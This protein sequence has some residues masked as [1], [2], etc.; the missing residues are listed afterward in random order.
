MSATTLGYIGYGKAYT[1]LAID[2]I[3]ERIVGG[4]VT[5]HHQLANVIAA[6][7]AT[8][9][10]LLTKEAGSIVVLDGSGAAHTITL[11]NAVVGLKYQF[12]VGVIGGTEGDISV[13]ADATGTADLIDGRILQTL[14]DTDTV[15][16]LNG[17]GILV[18]IDVP[19]VV[20]DSFTLTCYA[21][22]KW[23]IEGGSQTAA[24]FESIT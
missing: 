14:T 17:L 18:N 4:G 24:V 11:P 2:S 16:V 10:T 13:L 7:T 9:R 21:A 19:A 3:E 1:T 15:P 20:G 12:V 8:D 6:V 22:D 5:I 23:L